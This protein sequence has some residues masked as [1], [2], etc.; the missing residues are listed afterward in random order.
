MKNYSLAKIYRID[1]PTGD[2]YV[3]SNVA[4]LAERRGKHVSASKQE[5][6]KNC[7]LYAAIAELSDGWVGIHPVLIE[8][9]P[10]NDVE[11][12]RKR[13][14]EWI[15]KTGTLNKCIPGRTWKV[16]QSGSFTKKTVKNT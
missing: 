6:K 12:L 5:K 13:E 11:K 10:C 3:G 2:C 9:Y 14:S 4:S 7:P 15:R 1:L 8:K 16:R